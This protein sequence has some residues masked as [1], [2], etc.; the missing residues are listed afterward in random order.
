MKKLTHAR[1][2]EVAATALLAAILL[3]GGRVLP[4]SVTA[5]DAAPGAAWSLDEVSRN[6]RGL[7]WRPDGRVFFVTS[8][9]HQ[10]V[11]RFDIR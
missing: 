7:T 2:L 3:A 8:T 11:Y 6:T 1:C 4:F 10:R 9:E 5:S